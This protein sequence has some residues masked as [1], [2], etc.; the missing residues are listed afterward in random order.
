MWAIA[1]VYSDKKKHPAGGED[2]LDGLSCGDT[3]KELHLS[4]EY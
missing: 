2:L 3:A 4:A 1:R